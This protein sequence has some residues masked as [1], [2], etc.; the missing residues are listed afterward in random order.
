[1]ARFRLAKAA[2]R[3]LIEIARYTLE[4]WGDAQR[5][6]YLT[7]LDTWFR[8]LARQPRRGIASDDIKPGYWRCREGRHVICYRISADGVDIIRVL[9]ARMLPKRHL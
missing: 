9:H 4:Q 7:Q 6:R 8:K 2:R 3:D 1:M 5:K